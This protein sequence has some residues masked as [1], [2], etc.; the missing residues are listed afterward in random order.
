MKKTMPLC[1][2]V[3]DAHDGRISNVIQEYQKF[4]ICKGILHRRIAAD[5]GPHTISMDI[6]EPRVVNPIPL[7]TPLVEDEPITYE[8][9]E[10]GTTKGNR[11]IVD[12]GYSYTQKKDNR[13]GTVHWR[14]RYYSRPTMCKYIMKHKD[15]ETEIYTTA[16]LVPVPVRSPH[17]HTCTPIIG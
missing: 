3:M 1:V 17:P 13:K 15:P 12:K 4:D 7:P 10:A 16:T 8:L 5:Y 11:I 14:C 6:Q 9:I 2:M